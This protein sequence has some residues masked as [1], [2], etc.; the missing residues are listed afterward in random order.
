VLPGA[1]DEAQAKTLEAH[2]NAMETWAEAF[3]HA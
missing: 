2:L 1:D 3:R